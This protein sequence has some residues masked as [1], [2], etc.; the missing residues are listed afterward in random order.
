MVQHL[1]KLD[2]EL[3]LRQTRQCLLYIVHTNQV[4][5]GAFSFCV[6][7]YSVFVFLITS[8]MFSFQVL[9]FE[10]LQKGCCR[11]MTINSNLFYRQAFNQC[12]G[13]FIVFFSLYVLGRQCYRSPSMARITFVLGE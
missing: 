8:C 3:V 6:F 5:H 13:A 10:D 12:S 9:S 1:S 7:P 4:Q 2:Y 11:L